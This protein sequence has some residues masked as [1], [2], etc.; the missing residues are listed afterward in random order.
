VRRRGERREG[1]EG[2]TR[3][4]GGALVD[5]A[6]GEDTHGGAAEH[7]PLLGVHVTQ[8]NVRETRLAETAR[9]EPLE[10]G[11]LGSLRHTLAHLARL[12]EPD[13][14]RRDADDE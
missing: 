10:P 5:V 2:W 1:R 11:Q 14:M 13:V 3:A 7:A 6:H 12:V 9:R 4:G 8:P